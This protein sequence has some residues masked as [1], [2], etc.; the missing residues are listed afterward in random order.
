MVRTGIA[1]FQNDGVIQAA[2]AA[3]LIS[4]ERRKTHSS[5]PS[6]RRE[7]NNRLDGRVEKNRRQRL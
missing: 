2:G 1:V 3:G 6:I 7:K 5:P 4:Y